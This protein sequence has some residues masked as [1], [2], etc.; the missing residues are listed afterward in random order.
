MFLS[1]YPPLAGG[2]VILLVLVWQWQVETL[3]HELDTMATASVE[4]QERLLENK[5]DYVVAD[6]LTLSRQ[7]ELRRYLEGGDALLLESI[8]REYSARLRYSGLYQQIR[9]LDVQGRERVRV[10]LGAD[11][12][13]RITTG[14]RDAEVWRDA[15][16]L[17]LGANEIYVSAL[18]LDL[19]QGRIARPF[20]PTLRL[21]TPVVDAAGRN[22]GLIVIH[23][24]AGRLLQRL[25][26]VGR[27]NPARPMLVN[28][29]GYWLLA[30]EA[31]MRWGF[32][33]PERAH[34]RMQQR[35]PRVWREMT[36]VDRGEVRTAAGFFA[37]H[38]VEPLRVDYPVH[39]APCGGTVAAVSP[40]QWYTLA[41]VPRAHYERAAM[42]PTVIIGLLGLLLLGVLAAAVQSMVALYVNRRAQLRQLERMART[43]ALTGMANRIAFEERA[44]LEIERAA[45][46]RR[47]F[48]LCVIDLD[49]FKAINDTQGHLAGD[50]V[51]GFVAGVLQGQLR[52]TS[53][54]LAGRI[55]GDEF[56]L[57][58]T[59][60]PG[61]EAARAILEDI[62]RLIAEGDWGGQRVSASIGAALY[63]QDARHLTELFQ[64][65]DAAMYR[66]KSA[67]KDRVVLTDAAAPGGA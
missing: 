37:F 18:D 64:L 65:A 35:F 43:D 15:G 30:P 44:R 47:C 61:P 45:R 12:E 60:L 33:L 49:G 63:P 26:D 59:E 14:G 53:G 7:N 28:C 48:A 36:R 42:T 32:M 23:Y 11:G 8:A 10:E 46:H 1:I 54:D 29:A 34:Q 62:R 38:R 25:E 22:R 4:E 17:A 50:A 9:L 58:L 2:V 3:H 39:S 13:T 51:L 56:G 16:A 20:V 19:V 27:G 40:L 21:A 57:L 66:A 55:G 67:G 6:V 52:T 41:F 5:L 24:L 31:E